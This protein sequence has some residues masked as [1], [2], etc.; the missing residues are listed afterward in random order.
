MGD[1]SSLAREDNSR[2]PQAHLEDARRS[3]L[4][5]DLAGTPKLFAGVRSFTVGIELG[6]NW[7]NDTISDQ[8]TVIFRRLFSPS[9]DQ[10]FGLLPLVG[11]MVE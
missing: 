10:L 6:C 5:L 7:K 3:V 1:F 8:A 4:V 2:A 9:L 11:F